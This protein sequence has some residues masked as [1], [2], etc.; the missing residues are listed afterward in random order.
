VGVG[1]LT[2]NPAAGGGEGEGEGGEV[3]R[4]IYEGGGGGGGGGVHASFPPPSPSSSPAS[5]RGVVFSFHVREDSNKSGEPDGPSEE[6][7]SKG[8]EEKGREI[9]PGGSRCGDAGTGR[10][11]GTEKRDGETGR[12]N[13]N[14][15]AG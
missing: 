9:H 13:G 3:R 4:W 1:T 14:R 8:V 2:K 5:P 7:K 6:G 12:G 10:R 15:E 11:N